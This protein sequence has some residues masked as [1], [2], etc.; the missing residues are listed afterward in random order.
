MNDERTEDL[1]LTEWQRAMLGDR[2]Q[3]VQVAFDTLNRRECSV[4]RFRDPK[5]DRWSTWDLEGL[6]AEDRGRLAEAIRIGPT[7]ERL[8]E[9][10]TEPWAGRYLGSVGSAQL[11]D[12][13]TSNKLGPFD[14]QRHEWSGFGGLTKDKGDG[15]RTEVDVE[16]DRWRGNRCQHPSCSRPAAKDYCDEHITAL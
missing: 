10:T 7:P 2:A 14:W 16:V 4:W 15:A 8:N 13:N 11:E 1:I 12:S 6:S 9:M 5:A 3:W